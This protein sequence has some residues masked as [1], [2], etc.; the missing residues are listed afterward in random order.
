MGKRKRKRLCFSRSSREEK[1][2]RGLLV[3]VRERYQIERVPG[4]LKV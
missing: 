1:S 3:V 4:G 2:K